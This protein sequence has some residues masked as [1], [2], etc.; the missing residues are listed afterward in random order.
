MQSKYIIITLFV[1]MIVSDLTKETAGTSI[2]DNR[3]SG[4]QPSEEKYFVMLNADE[5]TYLRCSACAAA[6]HFNS[7]VQCRPTPGNC[8]VFQTIR[9]AT[10]H[11]RSAQV[12]RN[13][14]RRGA[15]EAVRR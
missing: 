6:C 9:S 15:R 4:L 8:I 5:Q 7:T 14:S 11:N 2:D 10:A 13:E 1:L 3:R 12:R